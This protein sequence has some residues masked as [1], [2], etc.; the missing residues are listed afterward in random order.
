MLRAR[1]RIDWSHRVIDAAD[2]LSRHGFM[3]CWIIG[4][5]LP[6]FVSKFEHRKRDVVIA[7][8]DY[9]LLFYS[10]HTSQESKYCGAR[11]LSWP[12]VIGG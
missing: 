1:T 4:D 3:V 2:L 10:T 8:H 11:I 12:T 6:V 5:I 9:W 7:L